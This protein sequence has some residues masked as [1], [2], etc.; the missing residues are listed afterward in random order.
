MSTEDFWISAK[1]KGIIKLRVNVKSLAS[2]AKHLRHEEDRYRGKKDHFGTIFSDI[3]RDHR[4]RRVRGEAR[5][6][7][8]SMAYL[9][10]VPYRKV[11]AKTNNPVQLDQLFSKV[12]KFHFQSSLTD[13]DRWLRSRATFFWPFS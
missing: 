12:K 11:E 13:L 7:Q 1:R 9:R 2:E 10:G 8:L 5:L 4:I 3:F 6:A